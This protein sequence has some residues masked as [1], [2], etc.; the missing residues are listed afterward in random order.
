MADELEGLIR[1]ALMD[2]VQFQEEEGGPIVG[3]L[4]WPEKSARVMAWR[5][6]KKLREQGELAVAEVE[7]ALLP[8][9]R[10]Q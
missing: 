2:G 6:A 9:D 7:S 10:R 4:R 8:P 5:S 3:M 1:D